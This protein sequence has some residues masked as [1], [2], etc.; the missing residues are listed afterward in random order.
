MMVTRKEVNSPQ[1][2]KEH[3]EIYHENS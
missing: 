2:R 1:R 3:R